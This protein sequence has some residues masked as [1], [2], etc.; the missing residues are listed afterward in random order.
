MLERIKTGLY[1][2]ELYIALSGLDG[3]TGAHDIQ[4]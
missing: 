4:P 2:V 3:T 1:P